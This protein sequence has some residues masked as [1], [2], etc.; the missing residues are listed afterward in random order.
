M[1]ILHILNDGPT[2]L[3]DAVLQT[4][5]ESHELQV[6][7]LSQPDGPKEKLYG[8]IV[9]AIFSCDRVISW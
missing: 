9:D 8:S 4:Q 6:I 1:K 7:D 3:S 2:P 5:S